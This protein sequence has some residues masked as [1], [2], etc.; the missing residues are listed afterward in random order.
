MWYAITGAIA[1]ILIIILSILIYHFL[2]EKEKKEA[3]NKKQS[4]RI[5]K[6]IFFFALLFVLDIPFVINESYK[7]GKGYYTLWGA[8]DILAFYGSF[9]SFLGT[10][11]LGA[12]ALWQNKQIADQSENYDNLLKEMKINLNTP[13]FNVKCLGLSNNCGKKNISFEIKNISQNLANN[14]S[15]RGFHIR[16]KDDEK[17]WTIMG[18]AILSTT[19]LKADDILTVKFEYDFK[20]EN[21]IVYWI[22]FYMSYTDKFNEKHKIRVEG[23]TVPKK[24]P[25]LTDYICYEVDKETQDFILHGGQEETEND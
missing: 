25:D 10:V 4:S 9:L 6:F 8:D 21:N 2:K 3:E 23:A 11:V 19:Y 15:I 12:L 14:I 17:Q 24:A 22:Y 7:F 13:T 1:V 16:K 18:N 20:T 5:L